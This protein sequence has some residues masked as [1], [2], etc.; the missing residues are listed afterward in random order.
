M[1]Q[2]IDAINGTAALNF[3]FPRKDDRVKLDEIAAGFAGKSQGRLL[4][5]CIGALDGVHFKTLSSGQ[6][7][8]NYVPRKGYTA[9]LA[10]AIC[11]AKR[12]FTFVSIKKEAKTHDS[13]AWE[14]SDLGASFKNGDYSADGYYLVGDNAYARRKR[15]EVPAL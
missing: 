9:I 15:V 2:V 5:R 14:S 6:H 12:E 11:N 7:T 1:R 13:S 10:Q 3:V 4:D 8:K